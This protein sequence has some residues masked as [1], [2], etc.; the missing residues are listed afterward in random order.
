MPPTKRAATSRSSS[1]HFPQYD[2]LSI[3]AEV[4]IS[5]ELIRIENERAS[6]FAS[7][8]DALS[9]LVTVADDIEQD[10]VR[11]REVLRHGEDEREPR[12][13][14]KSVIASLRSLGH[15]AVD[16]SSSDVQRRRD[17]LTALGL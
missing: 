17:T 4:D 13:L 9:T 7:S 2:K 3:T 15:G 16:E 14:R 6:T 12:G 10:R 5:N 11:L 8:S 1:N